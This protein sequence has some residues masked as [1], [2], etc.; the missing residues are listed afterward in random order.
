MAPRPITKPRCHNCRR[1]KI[2][3]DYGRPAC[4]QC[5]RSHLQCDGY[6]RDLI[7]VSHNSETN[8]LPPATIESHTNASFV[9]Q[10]P[11]D[12]HAA[13]LSSSPKHGFCPDLAAFTTIGFSNTPIAP[14]VATQPLT[15]PCKMLSD[16]TLF[17]IPEIRVQFKPLDT[18][19]SALL[20]AAASFTSSGPCHLPQ[21]HSLY[22]QALF[23]LG[24]C[25]QR[26]D[27][28]YHSW[29]MIAFTSILLQL[30]E[31]IDGANV[32]I[33]DWFRHST[34]IS[35]MPIIRSIQESGT[36]DLLTLTFARTAMLARAA[37]GDG[38]PFDP[39]DWYLQPWGEV[40]NDDLH[41]V[42][43]VVAQMPYHIQQSNL[44]ALNPY[45]CALK[46]DF[47]QK[48]ER[49]SALV[50]S[51]YSNQAS[52]GDSPPR[53]LH[54]HE[55]FASCTDMNASCTSVG[56]CQ[57]LVYV[58]LAQIMLFSANEKVRSSMPLTPE[59]MNRSVESD[60]EWFLIL[61]TINNMQ[62]A[63]SHC[64]SADNSLVGLQTM[65][66]PLRILGRFAA[67]YSLT[68]AQD[69]CRHSIQGLVDRNCQF[70]S[71]SM[72]TPQT[73]SAS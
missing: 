65:V 36:C 14:T 6:E 66:M 55:T 57:R 29:H 32:P 58:W 54:P 41:R 63:I 46:F 15:L 4:S 13:S 70:A 71:W 5:K 60:L 26:K 11:S 21:S 62:H 3:C 27:L 64:I 25:T 24:R 20:A 9:V 67:S 12:F 19:I 2:K 28:R 50:Q 72:F 48:H 38:D 59:S 33:E 22:S 39:D 8:D 44:T 45:D 34:E 69:W 7:F 42:I 51:I 68:D 52:H 16:L 1:K 56:T 43:D 61:E 53:V 37:F 40:T 23:E 49:L 47:E 73:V 31:V 18:A 35:L 10:K 30:V 17:D